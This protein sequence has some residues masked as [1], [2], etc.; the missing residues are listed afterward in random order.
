MF[1]HIQG[2][3]AELTPTEVIVD[4]AGLGYLVNISLHT[5]SAIS[6]LQE[7]RLFLHPIYREDTQALYGFHQKQEREVFRQLISV[8]GVGANTARTILST[9]SPAEIVSGIANGDV[10]MLQSV[11]G[12]GA[13]SAQRIIVDLKDKVL[14]MAEEMPDLSGEPHQL[15]PEAMAALEVLGYNQRQTERVLN[16][17][18]K[19]QADWT[20]EGLI[21]A[22]LQ[23]L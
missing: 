23:K 20:I 17:L 12:I 6:H 14:K 19:Q 15:K 13:K 7:V 3:V 2:K 11:K 10:R 9:L 16:S 8:S 1:H 4:C 22:A 5:Y 18:I 21:K